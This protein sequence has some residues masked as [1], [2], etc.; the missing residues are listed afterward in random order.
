MKEEY[1]VDGYSFTTKEE[2]E[3]AK[4]ELEGMEYLKGRTN[5]ENINEVLSVYNKVIDKKL[6]ITPVGFD[7]LKELQTTLV[8][9]GGMDLNEIKPIPV[10]AKSL[11]AE[12]KVKEKPKGEENSGHRNKL[13]N[14]VIVN[15]LLVIAI[16]IIIII[17]NNSQ[18]TNVLNYKARLDR[19]YEQR[20]D[21]LAKW[22]QELKEKELELKGE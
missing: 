14:L 10:L 7:F 8:E 9:D 18:N 21:S 12:K 15:I 3:K 16:V 6:F 4:K 11:G 19:E 20:E 2:Y 17:T 5:F 22:S 1:V 13:I